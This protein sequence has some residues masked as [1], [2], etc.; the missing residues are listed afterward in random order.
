MASK[1]I[2]AT[3]DTYLSSNTPTT[4]YG[5][6]TDFYFGEYNGGSDT[7]RTLIKFSFATN[8]STEL[9]QGYVVVSSASI[10]V[11]DIGTDFTNNARTADVYRMIRAWTEGTATWNTT[12]GSTSWGTA[13]AANT[14]NDRES[15]SIGSQSFPN[16]PSAGTDYTFSL[17]AS[18]VEAMINGSFTD[19]GFLI[20]MQTET[21]DMHRFYSRENGTAANRPDITINY[22]VVPRGG[23]PLF[24]STGVAIG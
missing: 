1:I 11:R 13:G 14:T 12:D 7:T 17:T 22:S 3:G 19:N 8:F 2:T 18:A 23:N 5:S 6:G 20:K 9:A 15:T 10:R 16:P 21:D 24:F 4:A